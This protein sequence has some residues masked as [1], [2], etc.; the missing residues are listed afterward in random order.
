MAL[1]DYPRVLIVGSGVFIPNTGGG[2]T[3][4]NL[5]NGWP[6]ERIAAIH[7]DSIS[8][9]TN[10]CRQFYSLNQAELGWMWPFSL[11]VKRW[12]KDK[13][14]RISNHTS[15]ENSQNS[16][17]NGILRQVARFVQ[18]MISKEGFQ[19]RVTV[20]KSLL[21]W[22]HAFQPD[23][24]YTWLGSLGYIRLVKQ[25]A[26]LTGASV[27]IHIMDDWPATHYRHGVLSLLFRWEM[28]RGFRSLISKAAICMGICP[29][30]CNAYQKCYNR[31]FLSFSNALDMHQW[32]VHARK[33]W[34]PG[35]PFRILYAGSIFHTTSLQ[36]VCEAVSELNAEG[37][38]IDMFI[39][40]EWSYGTQYRTQFERFPNVRLEGPLEN[41]VV[42]QEM[43]SADLLV[44]PVNFDD[45]S[46]RYIRYSNPTKLPAYMISGTPILVYGPR[47]VDQVD[48]A[49]RDRWGYVVSEHGVAHIKTAIRT[50]VR[51]VALR[52]KLGR[53]AQEVAQ[54]DHD[55]ATVRPAFQQAL[56]TA[57]RACIGRSKYT[58]CCSV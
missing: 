31:T 7:L 58:D 10:V 13:A 56:I 52:E 57:A 11:L 15:G 41:E 55:I 44:L 3:L 2:I 9:S 34:T 4:T 54:R 33:D 18:E 19:D 38:S 50:L 6:A 26:V 22:V 40:A 37:M 43:A 25:L 16:W 28:E 36:D 45:E 53:R 17:R 21:D 5:F 42:A 35:H 49:Q 24:I 48:R 8:P 46:V 1:S 27:A 23:V 32:R 14:H 30:M 12:Q 39:H 20:S 29:A 51:D 47:G